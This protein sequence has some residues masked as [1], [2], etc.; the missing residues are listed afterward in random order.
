MTFLIRVFVLVELPD[1]VLVFGKHGRGRA[2]AVGDVVLDGIEDDE[3]SSLGDDVE[4]LTQLPDFGPVA[5]KIG[6]Q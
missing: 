5:F 1:P 2:D 4:I 6:F 3:G